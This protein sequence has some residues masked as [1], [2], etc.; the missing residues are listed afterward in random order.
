M[1]S[2]FLIWKNYDWGLFFFTKSRVIVRDDVFADNTNS[3]NGVVWAPHALSHQAADKF[4]YVQNSTF[5]GRTSSWDCSVDAVAPA[6]TVVNNH[7]RAFRS[8][9]GETRPCEGK[10]LLGSTHSKTGIKLYPA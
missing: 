10:F 2:G 8:P 7:Q 5:I 4:V 9:S 6:T 1:V 3:I